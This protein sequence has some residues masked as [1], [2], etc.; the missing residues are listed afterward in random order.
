MA[1]ERAVVPWPGSPEEPWE[2]PWEDMGKAWEKHGKSMGNHGKTGET[3]DDPLGPLGFH[4]RTLDG[5]GNVKM[6]IHW[7][8]FLGGCISDKATFCAAGSHR[9]LVFGPC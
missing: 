3:Y 7:N 9:Q 4:G 1:A 5:D 8:Q 6:M 2:K